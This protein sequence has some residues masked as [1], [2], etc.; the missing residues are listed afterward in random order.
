MKPSLQEALVA[1]QRFR[2]AHPAGRSLEIRLLDGAAHATGWEV[3]HD[4][5]HAMGK[6]GGGEYSG[7]S[8]DG[9]DRWRAHGPT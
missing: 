8:L 5:N 7:L 4:G 9:E 3:E 6:I 2:R 1:F